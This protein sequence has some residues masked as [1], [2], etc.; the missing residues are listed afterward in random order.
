MQLKFEKEKYNNEELNNLIILVSIVT[1][2]HTSALFLI[3]E[4][5][6]QLY[7]K[8]L[9]SLSRN[10]SSNVSIDLGCG[11]VGWVAKNSKPVNIGQFK[12]D[13]KTLQYYTAEEN[14]KSFVA[15]PVMNKN[16]LLGVL[17]SDSKRNYL[18]NNKQEKIL[19]VFA[20]QCRQ[21]LE[22][23]ESLAAIKAKAEKYNKIY[24]HYTK[25]ANCSPLDIFST[26]LEASKEIINFDNCILALLDKTNSCLKLKLA[27]G[28]E[29]EFFL[30][31]H[32]PSDQGLAGLILK[33]KKPLLINNMKQR[34][35]K[36]L[37]FNHHGPKWD[38]DSFM[39]IPLFCAGKI[40]GILVY[41][42]RASNGFSQQDVQSINIITL[43]AAAIIAQWQLQHEKEI[44]RKF[45]PLT[46]LLN[47]SNFN[48]QL[49]QKLLSATILHPV[50][51]ILIDINN[52]AEINLKYGY[53]TGDKILI[54]IANILKELVSNEECLGRFAGQRFAMSL[55][56]TKSKSAK[57]MAQRI[58]SIMQHFRF[59][60]GNR[61][62]ALKVSIGLATCPTD[63]LDESQ[64]LEYSQKALKIAGSRRS[65]YIGTFNDLLTEVP[66]E[67]VRMF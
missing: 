35:R 6:N 15:V 50:S 46:G 1:Y 44:Q 25:I 5:K 2:A 4:N 9:Y 65:G 58:C 12:N 41:T 14:I 60:V 27:Y 55:E 21:L 52:L 34:R 8:A 18:F 54:K 7:I 38:M 30:D 67:K 24:Q 16:K 61:E 51:L 20:E 28:D 36:W 47:N 42:S 48:Q 64:L 19:S 22:K 32:F 43:Q 49:R 59:L 33:Q 26:L 10:L 63:A 31:K 37:V 62:I 13:P 45:D 57:E 39:G 11:L 53:E 56:N 17:T 3:D 23:E 29:C 40:M 66:H